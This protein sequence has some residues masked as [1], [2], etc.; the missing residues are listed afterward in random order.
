MFTQTV[1]EYEMLCFCASVGTE[2]ETSAATS[3]SCSNLIPGFVFIMCLR[4]TP[5]NHTQRQTGAKNSRG[6]EMDV[7]CD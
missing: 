7:G 1:W 6:S 3:C 2:S 4:R 5:S